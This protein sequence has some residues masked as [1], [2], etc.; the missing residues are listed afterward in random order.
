M[1]N[2]FIVFVFIVVKWVSYVFYRLNILKINKLFMHNFLNTNKIYE[3]IR[4]D[5]D[6]CVRF[7]YDKITIRTC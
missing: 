1:T 3:E 6:K 7:D 2:Q 4:R 5:L